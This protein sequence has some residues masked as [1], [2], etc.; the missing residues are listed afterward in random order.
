MELRA[1]IEVLKKFG[2]VEVITVWTDSEY[3]RKGITQW[4]GGVEREWLE[5]Y[6]AGAVEIFEKC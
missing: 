6:G 5:A 3:A 4:D 1:I 2:A